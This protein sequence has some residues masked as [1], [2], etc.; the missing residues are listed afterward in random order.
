[1][2]GPMSTK[3]PALPASRIFQMVA[4]AA[5]AGDA[6]GQLLLEALRDN[7]EFLTK[8]RPDWPRTRIAGEAVS[9]AFMRTDASQAPV[10]GTDREQKRPTKRRG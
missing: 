9:I 4:A 6:T 2:P 10:A 8:A 7:Q 3:A 1:M 5:K